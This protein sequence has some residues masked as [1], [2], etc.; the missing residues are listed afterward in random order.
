MA[1]DFRYP[2]GVASNVAN[3]TVKAV[4]LESNYVFSLGSS[5]RFGLEG[6]TVR[7]Y[8]NNTGYSV[9][10]TTNSYGNVT[11]SWIPPA[12]G[13]YFLT[14]YFQASSIYSGSRASVV[15]KAEVTP[16]SVLFEVS[17]T[18]FEPGR[19]LTLRARVLNAI[20]GLALGADYNV[21]FYNVSESRAS[22]LLGSH[23]TNASGYASTTYFYPNDG[24]AYAFV[25][26]VS[27][28]P[29]GQYSPQNIASSPVQLVVSK[30]TRLLL[31]V[32]RDNATSRHVVRGWL[33]YSS[34]GVYDKT[35][36]ITVN[37]TVYTVVTNGSGYFGKS[38]DLQPKDNKPTLYMITVQ[39]EGDNARTA[40]AY[41]KMPNGAS[42]A[43][44]TT[45]H[46]GYKPS[47]NST[48]LTIEPQATQVTQPTKTPEQTQQEAVQNGWLN[49]VH[50]F[51][52]IWYP[53]YRLHLNMS[54]ADPPMDLIITPLALDVTIKSY[55]EPRFAS[56]VEDAFDVG[57]DFV[58]NII[59]GNVATGIAARVAGRTSLLALFVAV[60]VNF[61][62]QYLLATLVNVAWKDPRTWFVSFIASLISAGGMGFIGLLSGVLIK[63]LSGA[64]RQIVGGIRSAMQAWRCAGL[65][66]VIITD[67][68]FIFVDAI[69]ALL[70]YRNYASGL[71]Y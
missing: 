23:S 9:S 7:F 30:A 55:D 61:G 29:Q 19:T 44:C 46:F 34:S 62:L 12:E 39:F 59:I 21:K 1:L 24:K 69:L 11:F 5:S 8:V 32:T 36:K 15:V 26:N 70:F 4:G 48:T 3:G 40:T 50:E 18:D 16:V 6:M 47:G 57:Y 43:V 68:A 28:S 35:V 45:T 66:F 38:F 41:S 31:N 63:W 2:T 54:G 27:A 20:S 71:V 22:H 10:G 67:I 58:L 53:W 51:T 25:A 33:K 37:G 42:F 14:A 49:V 60:V 65:T 13:T 56:Q 52:G 64:A 17:P